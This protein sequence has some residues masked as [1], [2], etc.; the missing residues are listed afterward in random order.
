MKIDPEKSI[1]EIY[2]YEDI[3]QKILVSFC[4]QLNGAYK[5]VA[6]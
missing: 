6:L 4:Q 5:N 1:T 2:H 3:I